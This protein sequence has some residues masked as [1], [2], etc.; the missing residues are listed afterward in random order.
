[1]KGNEKY[2]MVVIFQ[3][4]SNETEYI[5]THGPKEETC[6]DFWR[7]VFQHDVHVI[8]MVTNLTEQ[9]KVSTYLVLLMTLSHNIIWSLSVF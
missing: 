4:Y 1:L 2:G 7:M 9:D 5:A 8:V 3:G 6:L